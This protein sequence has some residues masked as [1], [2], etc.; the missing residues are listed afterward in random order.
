MSKLPSFF[1]SHLI[2]VLTKVLPTFW[3]LCCHWASLLRISLFWAWVLESEKSWIPLVVLPLT[4]LMT[5][6][7]SLSS[8]VKQESWYYQPHTE[9]QWDA[10]HNVPLRAWPIVH[11]GNTCCFASFTSWRASLLHRPS[12]WTSPPRDF[13][14][15][16]PQLLRNVVLSLVSA[17]FDSILGEYFLALGKSNFDIPHSCQQVKTER[18]GKRGENN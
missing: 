17:Q 13:V 2:R 12:A 3:I 9:T 14:S 8:P 15:Q 7:T 16:F 1:P 4:S 11:S 10:F 5:V 18:L 6:W